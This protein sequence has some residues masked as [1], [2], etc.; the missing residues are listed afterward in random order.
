MLGRFDVHLKPARGLRDG[1][2]LEAIRRG[3]IGRLLAELPTEQRA[4]ARNQIFDNMAGYHLDHSF[5]GPQTAYPYYFDSGNAA[6]AHIC[7]TN[8][9]AD[10]GY[11]DD[12]SAY[13]NLHNMTGSV[14]GSNAGKRFVE[15]GITDHVQES[16]PDGNGR[17]SLRYTERWLYLPTQIISNQI[18]SISIGFHTNADSAGN[19]ETGMIGRV[20]LKDSKGRNVAISKTSK[21]VLL[22]QYEFTLVTI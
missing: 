17:E 16:D 14:N 5:S 22:V 21:H 3:K 20:R 13:T 6:L 15:D 12:W 19:Q 11:T 10:P 9:D 4:Q 1:D 18:K 2:F 8:L 7:M